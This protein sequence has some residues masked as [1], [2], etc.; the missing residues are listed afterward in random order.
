MATVT[1]VP[2][3]RAQIFRD[4]LQDATGTITYWQGKWGTVRHD[5]PYR[6]EY[7]FHSNT[8]P[9]DDLPNVVKGCR[10]IFDAEPGQADMESMRLP[11]GVQRLKPN[12]S[13][14]RLM[15]FNR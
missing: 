12:V 2:A 3:S 6:V 4:G 5:G 1:T 14:A 9:P 11:A 8:L 10:M 13:S 15:N 7:Y